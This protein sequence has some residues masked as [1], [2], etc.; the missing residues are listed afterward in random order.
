MEPVER[1]DRE[2]QL[3]REAMKRARRDRHLAE[4]ADGWRREMFLKSHDVNLRA[5]KLHEDL[6]RMAEV[7]A[8]RW[9]PRPRL[10]VIDSPPEENGEPGD[11]PD[12]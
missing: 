5:A 12:R 11:D 4:D 9:R 1:A 6:A 3:A 8:E 2:R 10:E 7:H